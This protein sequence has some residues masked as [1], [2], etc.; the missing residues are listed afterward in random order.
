MSNGRRRVV[1]GSVAL[2][3][4]T[5]AAAPIVVRWQ[6]R[7]TFIDNMRASVC[8]YPDALA[9][10]FGQ[11]TACR[12]VDSEVHL[13]GTTDANLYVLLGTSDAR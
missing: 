7:S 1:W 9:E 10:P 8:A 3:A 5:A 13:L 11:V 12:V 2:V 4:V 6:S